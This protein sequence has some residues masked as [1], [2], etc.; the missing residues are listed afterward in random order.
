MIVETSRRKAMEDLGGESRLLLQPTSKW[1]T[2]HCKQ[3]AILMKWN[4]SAV[5]RPFALPGHLPP[6]SYSR[7]SE[8]II[9]SYLGMKNWDALQ[10]VMMENA[11]KEFDSSPSNKEQL[12]STLEIM[13]KKIIEINKEYQ[14]LRKI[15]NK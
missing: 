6:K 12:R 10:K 4:I 8:R 5:K 7:K 1:S 14:E 11:L 2:A 15:L 3:L 9:C 13:G